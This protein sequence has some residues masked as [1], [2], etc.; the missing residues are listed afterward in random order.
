MRV[1]VSPAAPPENN[2]EKKE[3][4]EHVTAYVRDKL[5]SEGTGHDW[6]HVERVR[7]L[8]LQ[9]GKEE[10]A[11]L[12]I[13][14]LA[15]LTHDLGDPKLYGGD[16]SAVPRACREVLL[17]HG[18]SQDLADKVAAVVNEVSFKG[19]KANTKASNLEAAV[20]QD[21]DRLD[22]IGAIGIGRSF[23]FGGKRS[24]PMHDPAQKPNLN[25][26]TEEYSQRL[27]T[28]IN[29]FYE[30]ILLVKDLLNTKTAKRLAQH[31][32]KFVETFLNEFLNEWEGDL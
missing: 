7:R 10:G 8:A 17:A 9:L 21:A 29:H 11:D 16:Y 4:I 3:L 19:P 31:R 13:V 22:A 6:W 18:A 25:L 23:A 24:R 28:T 12:S 1:R 5:S 27:G 32:H 26:T 30:K 14:E 2:M 20:V 15:A